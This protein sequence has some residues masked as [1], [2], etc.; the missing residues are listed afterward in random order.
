MCLFALRIRALKRESTWQTYTKLLELGVFLFSSFG[1]DIDYRTWP[2][3]PRALQSL[4]QLLCTCSLSF[5]CALSPPFAVGNPAFKLQGVV[6]RP[7]Y[8]GK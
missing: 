1:L 3:I 2:K 4:V 8:H 7:A 6:F 5:N